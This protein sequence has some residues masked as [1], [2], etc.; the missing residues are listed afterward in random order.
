MFAISSN[1]T[2]Q[3]NIHLTSMQ[4][5]FDMYTQG[6]SGECFVIKGVIR[7]DPHEIY[8]NDVIHSHLQKINRIHCHI[9]MN[10]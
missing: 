9:I 3:Y 8:R 1:S 6:F 10:M 7:H 2:Q 4:K 5:W